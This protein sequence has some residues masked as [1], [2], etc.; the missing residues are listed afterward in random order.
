MRRT[1]TRPAVPTA[2]IGIASI[3][4]GGGLLLVRVE[5]STALARLVGIGLGLIG[6]ALVVRR[7]DRSGVGRWTGLLWVGVGVGVAVWP[8]ATV[9]EVGIAAGTVMI[10]TASV[11]LIAARTRHGAG[12]V[13]AV[14]SSLAGAA[15]G[16]A[17]IAWPTLTTLV[18][19]VVVALRLLIGGIA[20]LVWAPAPGD[21]A[22]ATPT[23]GARRAVASVAAMLVAVAL[24]AV[25]VAVHRAQPA[26][27]GAFYEPPATLPGPPGTLIRSEVIDDYVAGGTAH[28]VLYV[29]TDVDGELVT[30][31][32][33]VIV[34]DGPAPPE[35]RPVYAWTHGT[36]GIARRCAPSL[37]DGPTYAP[38]IA[39]LPQQLAAGH[40]VVATD[41]AGLGSRATTGYLVGESQATSTLDAVRSAAEVPG[42]ASSGR[43]VVVGESQGGHA[44]LFTG[45]LVD[46]HAPELELLGVVAAAPATDLQALFEANLGTTFGDILAAFALASWSRTYDLD[47][48]EILH[49]DAVRVVER[50]A[51]L[52]L[53][54]E[55]QLL[56]VA[57]EAALLRRR[58]LTALPWETE[59]WQTILAENTPGSDPID[60]P[61]LVLQG[62]DDPLVLPA[63]QERFVES[64]CADGQPIDL[65]V[66][67]GVGHLDAGRATADIV[68][69][70][71]DDRVAGRPDTPTCP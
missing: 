22:R 65:R 50:V 23:V 10:V 1:R 34:P 4:L 25:S 16:V 62:A 11:D 60:A 9:R 17:A 19:A 20:L 40:L 7:R 35:G 48:D 29:T 38:S 49:P 33:L 13:V 51:E 15:L 30:S 45:Q 8:E 58:F 5:E 37:L 14:T 36:V 6:A 55:R 21:E 2:A 71:I 27:P 66:V 64:W 39:G 70:W 61:V 24:A 47:L 12:R 53:L 44:A 31:S 63:V 43:M 57:P 56:A 68:A 59:P 52:C 69:E 3:L 32:G 28:R 46:D 67:P 26:E 54:T 41:Y 18:L 42:A